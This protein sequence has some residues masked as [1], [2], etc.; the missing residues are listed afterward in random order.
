MII[1][2]QIKAR[3][4]MVFLENSTKQAF[5]PKCSQRCIHMYVDLKSIVALYFSQIVYKSSPIIFG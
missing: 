5:L 2:Y 4:F 3:L 1:Q